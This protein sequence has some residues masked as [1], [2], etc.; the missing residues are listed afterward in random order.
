MKSI[1]VS[2]LSYIVYNEGISRG[3]KLSVQAII[4]QTID[5]LKESFVEPSLAMASLCG[6][7]A[8]HIWSNYLTRKQLSVILKGEG[9]QLI[10]LL[11]SLILLAFNLQLWCLVRLRRSF[12]GGDML[13]VLSAQNFSSRSFAQLFAGDFKDLTGS[14]KCLR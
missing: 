7:N 12:V 8:G 13:H 14:N 9:F 4:F 2:F 5:F 3:G 10:N 1:S 11:N 6:L